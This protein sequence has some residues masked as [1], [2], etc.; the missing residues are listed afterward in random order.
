[1]ELF[2]QLAWK[3]CASA[4]QVYSLRCKQ[5]KH[6]QSG[7]LGLKQHIHRHI[8]VF[9]RFGKMMRPE[10]AEDW[11]H[12]L[13]DVLEGASWTL[14]CERKDGRLLHRECPW[15][16]HLIKFDFNFHLAAGSFL[17]RPEVRVAHFQRHPVEGVECELCEFIAPGEAVLRCSHRSIPARFANVLFGKMEVSS[18]SA[19]PG[20]TLRHTSRRD[21][22][23]TGDSTWCMVESSGS[24]H[25]RLI[26]LRPDAAK[27]QHR[28]VA[29]AQIPEDCFVTW[30]T[31]QLLQLL[32]GCKIAIEKTIK[33][34]N[35]PE[36]RDLDENLYWQLR[37][38]DFKRGN[39]FLPASECS[40]TV[41]VDSGESLGLLHWERFKG[42]FHLAEYMK[43]FLAGMG[44]DICTFASIDGRRLAPEHCVVHRDQW[45]RVRGRFFEAFRVQRSAYRRGSG[46]SNAPR[47]LEQEEPKFLHRPSLRPAVR[48]PTAQLVLRKTF[49][50]LLE[51]D[52]P[53]K[54]RRTVQLPVMVP[55]H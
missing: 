21:F 39:P 38:T 47:L 26:L 17:V 55:A 32:D 7:A 14:A 36:A 44:E 10:S 11:F 8:P 5:N 20:S 15:G 1:M 52:K 35:T 16:G 33:A 28:Y 45:Q 25:E 53:P 22:P 43:L 6:S 48:H 54:R 12:M 23:R 40:S 50:D 49:W 34:L 4:Q 2:F 27:G 51:H 29:V 3:S 41:R 31:F 24:R 46:G 9:F 30:A 42:E 18:Q 13:P 19:S 37:I